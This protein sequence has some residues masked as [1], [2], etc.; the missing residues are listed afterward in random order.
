MQLAS[1]CFVLEN[2]VFPFRNTMLGVRNQSF[3]MSFFVGLFICSMV[4]DHLF[5]LHAQAKTFPPYKKRRDSG[6]GGN[7]LAS[8]ISVC[9]KNVHSTVPSVFLMLEI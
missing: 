2:R 6:C 8:Y 5:K 4:E 9:S 1:N 7:G 3:I